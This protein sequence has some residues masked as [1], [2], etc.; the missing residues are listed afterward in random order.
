MRC[1]NPP[2]QGFV[3]TAPDDESSLTG[4]LWISPSDW[5]RDFQ[6]AG[7]SS[8][9]SEVASGPELVQTPP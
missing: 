1:D 7:S 6:V 8:L 2:R 4:A 9:G 5:Q 3:G